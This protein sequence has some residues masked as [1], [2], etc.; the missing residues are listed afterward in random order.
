MKDEAVLVPVD[1]RNVDFYGDEIV[2]ALVRVEE[3][4]LAYV[5]RSSL[6][7]MQAKIS[8]KAFLQSYIGV[9]G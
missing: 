2:T 3:Q 9:S 5:P 8:I 6:Q 7:R 4:T 1:E